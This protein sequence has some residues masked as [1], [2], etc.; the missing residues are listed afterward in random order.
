MKI[1]NI[2]FSF[3]GIFYEALQLIP[4]LINHIVDNI[5]MP[6]NFPVFIVIM[7]NKIFVRVLLRLVLDIVAPVKNIILRERVPG[8]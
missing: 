7:Y 1:F 3:F 4:S 6:L 5:F 8:F 2:T